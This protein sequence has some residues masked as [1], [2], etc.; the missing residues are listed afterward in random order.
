MLIHQ[1][2]GIAFQT[3]LGVPLDKRRQ[4]FVRKHST[5]LTNHTQ[6]L[7]HVILLWM[8]FECRWSTRTWWDE[9]RWFALRVSSHRIT[10]RTLDYIATWH[11]SKT[12]SSGEPQWN[13]L[14]FE[15]R[16][17]VWCKSNSAVPYLCRKS[18]DQRS[19]EYCSRQWLWTTWQFE[20][21]EWYNLECMCTSLIIQHWFAN[22]N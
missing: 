13:I 22:K 6:E 11:C 20:T 10:D 9:N 18:N 14:S 3:W 8:P 1:L 4:C 7:L 19:G 15:S 2:Y 21:T 12:Y 5:P 16:F 17:G